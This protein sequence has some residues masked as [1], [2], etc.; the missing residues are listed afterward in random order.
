LRD[1]KI[2]YVQKSKQDT[3]DYRGGKNQKSEETPATDIQYLQNKEITALPVPENQ[4]KHNLM[5][6]THKV[7]DHE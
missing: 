7:S 6:I 1:D 2:I 3:K 5:S 4:N